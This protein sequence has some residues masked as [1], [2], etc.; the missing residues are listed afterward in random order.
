MGGV[1]MK[2]GKFSYIT[3]KKYFDQW[4]TIK[5]LRILRQ[6]HKRRKLVVFWDNCPIHKTESVRKELKK[7]GIREIRNV[8]Y[9]P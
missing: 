3:S 8:P 1:S 6:E 9:R 4:E 2:T 7:L 5:F